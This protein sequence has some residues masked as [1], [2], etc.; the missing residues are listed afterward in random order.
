MNER[1]WRPVVGFE[2]FYEVSDDGLVMSLNY[3]GNGKPALMKTPPHASRQGYKRCVLR[4]D[5]VKNVRMLVHRMVAMAFIGPPPH[6]SKWTVNHKDGDKLN[7]RLENL[8]W[9]SPK[10]QVNHADDVLG[11][12]RRGEKCGMAKLANEQAL[13]IAERVGTESNAA[14]AL[15]Y[16]ITPASVYGIA[17]GSRWSSVTGIEPHRVGKPGMAKLTPADVAEIRRRRAKGE[18]LSS[19]AADFDVSIPTASRAAA[20]KTWKSAKPAEPTQVSAPVALSG[21]QQTFDF[22]RPEGQESETMNKPKKSKAPK[23]RWRVNVPYYLNVVVE[24][25]A[26]NEDEAIEKAFCVASP[27]LCHQCSGEGDL[28]EPDIED[29]GVWTEELDENGVWV[30]ASKGGDD[31]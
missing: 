10:D 15:E 19:I 16:G 21:C 23:K 3:R 9:A 27:S 7:N 4:N 25:D 11:K 5:K 22:R 18:V 17:T 28:G 14:L 13:E 24:V 12:H 30:G 29:E 20:G 2:G 6:P 31:A 1:R 26:D 8:E